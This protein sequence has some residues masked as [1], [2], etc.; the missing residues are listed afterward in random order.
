MANNGAAA[1]QVVPDLD[2]TPEGIIER[3]AAMREM[4]LTQQEDGEREGHYGQDVHEAFLRA[5]FYHILTPKRYGGLEMGIPTFLKVVTEIS[6]GDPSAGWCYCLGH[7][8]TLTTAAHWPPEAQDE[9]FSNPEGYFRAS[10]SVAGGGSIRRA[11]GG[12]VVNY[13]S[14]YQSGVWYST[15]A[16]VNV[17]LETDEDPA[18]MYVALVPR[19]Q[20]SILDDWGGDETIGLRASG[21]NTVLVE[22]AF[23]PDSLVLPFDWLERDYSKLS[24][25]CVFHSNP[26]Y[27]GPIGPFFHSELAAPMVGAAYAAIDEYERIIT[28]RTSNFPPYA[29]RSQDPDHQADLGMAIT[30]A[31]A[32]KAVMLGGIHDYDEACRRTVEEGQPYERKLD[33]RLGAMIQRAG[34]MASDA[35]GMLYRS[36]GSSAGHRGQ[37]LQ[38]YFRDVSMYRGHI[39]AQYRTMARRVATTHMG[40]PTPPMRRSR[41]A[42]PAATTN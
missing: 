16:T 30:M 34:E 29:P 27:L 39:S 5:G 26:M 13:R 28:R 8:H 24:P 2:V 4:L 1:G 11:D 10:H 42:V 12:W 6:R 7:G 36:G 37:P 38:R 33:V 20:F 19:S 18:P 22:E 35:V 17:T 40:L 31:D 9:I 23:L 21:S 32:A 25:G 15:H 41:A 3:A 14:P